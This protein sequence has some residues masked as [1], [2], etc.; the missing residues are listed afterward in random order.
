MDRR[1]IG[2]QGSREFSAF[3]SSIGPPRQ[4]GLSNNYFTSSTIKS[5][6]LAYLAGDIF[7][8]ASEVWDNSK[9]IQTVMDRFAIDLQ[10]LAF[11]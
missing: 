7:K 5:A 1:A 3:F 9:S 4:I 6:S 10:L 2:N 11:G 8:I